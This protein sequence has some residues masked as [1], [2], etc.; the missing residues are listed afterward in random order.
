MNKILN[1]VLK[2]AQ[3]TYET[4]TLTSREPPAQPEQSQIPWLSRK[5]YG[6]H[7]RASAACGFTEIASAGPYSAA[8]SAGKAQPRRGSPSSPRISRSL[9]EGS[10]CQDT[11]PA[12]TRACGGPTQG[13]A[14]ARGEPS[15]RERR[16]PRARQESPAQQRRYLRPR[17]PPLPAAPNAPPVPGGGARAPPTCCGRRKG[18]E[19][20]DSRASPA[21]GAALAGPR[22]VKP[23][24]RPAPPRRHWPRG[25]RETF[26]GT[27]RAPGG[28]GPAA[29]PPPARG[30][31]RPGPLCHRSRPV[32]KVTLSVS[33][34]LFRSGKV[35]WGL[36][37]AISI[38]N[39][40]TSLSLRCCG[41]PALRASSCSPL[42]PLSQDSTVLVLR[43]P[44]LGAVLRTGSH[45]SREGESSLSTC[46]P[47]FFAYRTGLTFW[48]GSCPAFYPQ[49]SLS[50]SPQLLSTASSPSPMSQ[51]YLTMEDLSA[52]SGAG[53]DGEGAPR[54]PVWHILCCPENIN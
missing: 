27:C 16:S 20:S 39:N 46:W 6:S 45:A 37:R 3:V 48:V 35:W 14:P 53:S 11:Q 33:K 42:D 28:T 47:W 51:K 1:S 7:L 23:A 4:R 40:R 2:N 54:Y 25:C 41:A 15:P 9:R 17:P 12:R 5:L 8:G 22:G 31:N 29:P 36:P 21:A 44:E 49:Q 13:P 43:T 50:P 32:W 18:E 52:F 30:R 19:G 24:P 34:A 38:L 26:N 10:T